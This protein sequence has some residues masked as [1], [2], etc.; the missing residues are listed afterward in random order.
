MSCF[1]KI[2]FNHQNY[3]IC[4]II[5]S[6]QNTVQVC[7]LVMFQKIIEQLVLIEG[8]F[9]QGLT[10]VF[11]NDSFIW[12]SILYNTSVQLG[13][14]AYVETSFHSCDHNW[15]GSHVFN[16]V[17]YIGFPSL[18]QPQTVPAALFFGQLQLPVLEQGPRFS[19]LQVP[20]PT[21]WRNSQIMVRVAPLLCMHP[22]WY[23]LNNF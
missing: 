10:Q 18:I 1:L 5:R 13:H 3:C 23:M 11:F 6:P 4:M 15:T 8:Q 21:Q 14:Y 22:T 19:Y 12:R 9:T 16:S 20:F 17:P 7:L 2:N